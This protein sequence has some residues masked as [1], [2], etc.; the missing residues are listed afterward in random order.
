MDEDPW[1]EQKL[2]RWDVWQLTTAARAVTHASDS[3]ANMMLHVPESVQTSW[4]ALAIDSW[5]ALGV[6]L[7]S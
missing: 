7:G 4:V 3:D 2:K 6:D 1:R 5:D